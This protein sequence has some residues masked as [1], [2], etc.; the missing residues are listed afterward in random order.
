MLLVAGEPLAGFRCPS[1]VVFPELVSPKATLSA[2]TTRT[3]CTVRPTPQLCFLQSAVL[4]RQSW[5]SVAPRNI[6]TSPRHR[7]IP[8]SRRI[9][10]QA[11]VTASFL[12]SDAAAPSQPPPSQHSC[13]AS[14][15]SPSTTPSSP[16]AQPFVGTE[17]HEQKPS[18]LDRARG[19]LLHV[20]SALR[21][22][23]SFSRPH[24][25]YGSIASITSMTLI[26]ARV[27]GLTTVL[28]SLLTALP[29]AVLINVYIVGLNQLYDIEIDSINKPYLPLAAGRLSIAQ[30]RGIVLASL[31]A[32]LS[33]CFVP[34]ATPALRTVLVGS[35][36][37]GT[38]YSLPPIRLK[39]FA[40][41]A[42]F[43]ILS[44]RGMLINSCFFMHATATRSLRFA[45]LP[46]LILFSCAL[47]MIF[48]IVIALLKDV[49]DIRG[50]TYFN[51][52]TFTVRLG[53]VFVFKF[54]Q[55]LLSLMYTV[56]AL[57]MWKLT[58]SR[59]FATVSVLA[60]LAICAILLVLGK[61]VDPT[62]SKN[63]YKY[64]MNV[65]KAFYLEYALL[66]MACL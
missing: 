47:F 60:H 7:A 45:K 63:V 25:V 26:A 66:P 31:A 29:S 21:V 48:G 53:A 57:V 43:C 42:S 30:A 12:G 33:F 34:G 16:L 5:R 22:L 46:P 44:V 27:V 59:L 15:N 41:L 17:S 51:V 28:T 50:D 40:L 14:S 55:T 8:S 58:P 18:S 36:V 11:C 23:W 2:W 52:R 38:V 10:R 62:C 9:C 1:E 19:V 13:A 32:G 49:P 37:L 39:R 3:P 65:W 6:D 4:G 56:A 20:T 24:T 54:C 35:A 61:K 64:Y